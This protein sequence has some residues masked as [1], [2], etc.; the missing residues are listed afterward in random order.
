MISDMSKG[1]GRSNMEEEGYCS[2]EMA[3]LRKK[4]IVPEQRHFSIPKAGENLPLY[5]Y[6]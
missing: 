2:K 4:N 6:D 1:G 5:H 3:L